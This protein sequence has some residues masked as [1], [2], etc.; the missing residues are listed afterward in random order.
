MDNPKIQ[1]KK[2]YKGVIL[3]IVAFIVLICAVIIFYV[4]DPIELF[5][6]KPQKTCK[7]PGDCCGEDSKCYGSKCCLELNNSCSNSSDCCNKNICDDKDKKCVKPPLSPPGP[8]GGPPGPGGGPP[9]TTTPNTG[10]GCGTEGGWVKGG[11][12]SVPKVVDSACK[13]KEMFDKFN[14]D[15][16][17]GKSIAWQYAKPSATNNDANTCLLYTGG[18]FN[19]SGD[20][21]TKNYIYGTI[22]GDLPENYIPPINISGMAVPT[23]DTCDDM[24]D[25][26]IKPKS[27]S[28][29]N[30]LCNVY[31]NSETNRRCGPGVSGRVCSEG[32]SLPSSIQCS[33]LI[34][35]NDI[36][37]SSC[38][39][40][41]DNSVELSVKFPNGNGWNQGLC[42]G[43]HEGGN[44]CVGSAIGAGHPCIKSNTKKCYS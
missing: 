31:Y 13:C 32:V 12:V 10:D 34:P 24:K 28:R 17:V 33:Q 1:P 9:S 38:D 29:L 26:W 42:H 21:D 23:G 22:P 16:T 11:Q 37:A 14:K 41:T 35:V 5:C 6:K 8:G 43:Y 2:S 36:G 3:V 18:N 20:T 25:E 4:W 27:G 30:K 19:S 7:K 39:S 40:I 15:K 44:I